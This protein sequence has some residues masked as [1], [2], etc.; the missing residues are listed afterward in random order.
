MSK[1]TQGKDPFA[2]AEAVKYE[3]PIASREY[4]LQ[5]LGETGACS[6]KRLA[7]LVHIN[8]DDAYGLEAL[9]RR[10][11]AML[12]DMQLIEEAN[13]DVAV[14]DASQFIAGKVSAHKEG[15]GFVLSA[16][17]E[18]D[19]FL[20][21]HEM[22]KVFDGDDVLVSVS[23]VKRNGKKEASI[24]QV[25]QHNTHRVVGKLLRTGDKLRVVAENPK[26]HHTIYIAA[27]NTLQAEHESLVVVEITQQPSARQQAKGIIVKV[28][29]DRTTPGVEV[30]IALHQFAIPH[31]WP[32]A[33]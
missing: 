1:T 26:L 32:E 24:V 27:E 15:Y 13:G 20:N 7:K 5:V 28:L 8:K 3:S 6:F 11:G 31:E 16:Q 4:I 2:A 18:E 23:H 17:S 22:R 9:R 30:D 33:V 12:R 10:V 25:T 14:I 19:L 29:G 21:Y